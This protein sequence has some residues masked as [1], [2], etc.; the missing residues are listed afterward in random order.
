M[1]IE[2]IRAN[3]VENVED[4]CHFCRY[5]DL[6]HTLL[7]HLG[8]KKL[9]FFEGDNDYQGFLDVDVLLKDGRVFSYKYT[10]GSCSGCDEWESRCLEED[11][12]IECME[13]EATFFEDYRSYYKWAVNTRKEWKLPT[14]ETL[15]MWEEEDV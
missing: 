12:I 10:Y 8:A 7:V 6:L 5:S 2:L 1:L 11:Q 15:K 9:L 3:Q 14:I 13:Q 4:I